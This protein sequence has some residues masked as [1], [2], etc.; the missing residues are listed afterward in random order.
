MPETLLDEVTD[1]DKRAAVELLQTMGIDVG[2]ITLHWA[3][4]AM[5]RHRTAALASLQPSVSEMRM[6]EAL[7]EIAN[8]GYEGAPDIR[9]RRIARAALEG[10]PVESAAPAESKKAEC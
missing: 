4:T 2:Q 7:L 6:T 5:S 8:M 9:M 1:S 10:V 3:S